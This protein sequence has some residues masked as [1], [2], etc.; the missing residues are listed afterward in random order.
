MAACV[1]VSPILE[2]IA[3]PEARRASAYTDLNRIRVWKFHEAPEEYRSLHHGAD[4]PVW[5][6][7]VPSSLPADELELFILAR[8]ST[9]LRYEAPD[10][11]LIYVGS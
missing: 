4:S 11:S 2:Q 1:A 3:E 6:A 5:L 10:G 7:A 8:T 9:V